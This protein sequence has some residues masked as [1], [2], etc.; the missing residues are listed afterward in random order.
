MTWELQGKLPGGSGAYA[1]GEGAKYHLKK[2]E[3]DSTVMAE[4]HGTA[5]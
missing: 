2:G 1:E 5:A 4:G 3:M